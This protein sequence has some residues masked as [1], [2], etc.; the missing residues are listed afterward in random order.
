[1]K[2]DAFLLEPAEQINVGMMESQSSIIMPSH[3]TTVR[4]S[5]YKW[6][7]SGNFFPSS[8]VHYVSCINRKKE[9]VKTSL[10]NKSLNYCVFN[11]RMRVRIFKFYRIC[12]Q[13]KIIDLYCQ[14]D[15]C[16]AFAGADALG[17]GLPAIRHVYIFLYTLHINS[18][19]ENTSD[20]QL[21]ISFKLKLTCNYML[22]S[23]STRTLNTSLLG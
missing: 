4:P 5:L 7:A 6:L 10:V 23:T 3:L 20:I 8:S 2:T 19:N 14:Q 12:F 18:V 1:M 15:A 13:S 11:V 9:L 22:S 17:R 16:S 21:R